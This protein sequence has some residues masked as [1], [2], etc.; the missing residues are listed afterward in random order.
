MKIDVSRKIHIAAPED[1]A[2]YANPTYAKASGVSLIED[3]QHE[4]MHVKPDGSKHYYAKRLYRRRS[5][6]NGATWSE[7]K[8][9]QK[10]GPDQLEGTQRHSLGII[11]DPIHNVLINLFFTHE[12]DLEEGVFS[13][14]NLIQRTQRTYYQLSRDGGRNWTEP[15]QV[16]DS[17]P[18]YNETNW[19][20]GVVYGVQGA[21]AAGQHVFLPDGTLVIFLDVM[22]PEKPSSFPEK[23]AGYYITTF[24]AQGRLTENRDTVEWRFGEPIS[25]EFP[26]STMGCCE[27][28]LAWLGGTRLFNTMRCQGSEKYSIYSTRYTTLSEDG[29]I[30]WSDPVPLAYD[31][32]NT[33]WTSTSPHQF[34]PSPETG[35][36]YVIA[37][38]LPGPVHRQ[39]PRYSLAVAEFDTERLCVLRDTVQVIQ[40]LPWGAPESCGYTNFGMYAERGSGDLILL[41]PEQPKKMDFEDMTR[42]EDFESDCIEF[43]IR[44]RECGET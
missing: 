17:R 39:R 23:D 31:D 40:D 35:K 24:Y 20:P 1:A 29:G 8:E 14:G 34:F 12:V 7:E 2:V 26:N 44:F 32:G 37:N 21:R 5:E 4:A 11:L 28:V 6:D 42:P 43:R 27:Q 13:I 10:I 15:R 36:T 25:V 41:M 19:A 33:V 9:L 18:E 22:Q 30:T 3:V 16:I 38:I